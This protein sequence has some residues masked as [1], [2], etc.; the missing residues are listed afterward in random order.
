MTR[1]VAPLFVTLSLFPAPFLT[2]ARAQTLI[3][4]A[5]STEE[6]STLASAVETAGLVG[7]FS[8]PGPLTLFAPT[9][10][11]FESL[12]DGQLAALLA[13]PGALAELLAFHL[14]AGQLLASDVAALDGESAVTI[15]G[16]A[17]EVRAAGADITVGDARL[18]LTD[19]IASNGVVHAV[20]AVLVPARVADA[21]PAP[22]TG[23]D[24]TDPNDTGPDYTSTALRSARFAISPAASSGVGGSVLVA[25]YGP[26][27][28]VIV[29][30]LA[31]TPA[32]TSYAASLRSGDCGSGGA[33]VTPL[34]E[35]RGGSG[36]GVTTTDTPFD[37]IVEGDH[38]VEVMLEVGLEDG[39][40][41][42]GT[43]VG[44]AEVGA[45]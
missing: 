22:S 14:V 35:V 23:P 28:T 33:V 25:D 24:P 36:L 34:E 20:D 11:A 13:D 5:A 12:P 1:L 21:L 26:S 37:V 43:V 19:I 41:A 7:D 4:I 38:Y 27:R 31:G 30:G 16:E 32:G 29:I 9:N 3:D 2:A 6:F 15:Q 17:L 40:A 18:I 8:A 10:A 39:L 45:R 44:C 42:P